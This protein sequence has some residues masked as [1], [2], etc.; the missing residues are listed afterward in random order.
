MLRATR[1]ALLVASLVLLSACATPAS[2]PRPGVPEIP[3]NVPLATIV[4]E[5]PYTD[6]RLFLRAPLHCA[7]FLGLP[8]NNRG[9]R[10]IASIPR[11]NR[12][13]EIQQARVTAGSHIVFG[14]MQPGASAN[15]ESQQDWVMP[16][17]AGATYNVEVKPPSGFFNLGGFKLTVTKDGIPVPIKVLPLPRNSTCPEDL[18]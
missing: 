17:E 16:V 10:L 6:T 18:T 1:F 5:A 2:G 4:L 14:V 11:H 9:G 8:S 15:V 12:S 3:D 13:G 7:S